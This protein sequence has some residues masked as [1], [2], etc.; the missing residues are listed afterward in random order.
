MKCRGGGACRVL[1]GSSTVRSRER[2]MGRRLTT[3]GS[4]SNAGWACR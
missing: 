2:R 4:R 3:P 1:T